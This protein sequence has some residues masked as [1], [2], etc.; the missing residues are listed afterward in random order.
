MTQMNSLMVPPIASLSPS[1]MIGAV[2]D[3]IHVIFG[4]AQNSRWHVEAPFNAAQEIKFLV[5]SVKPY[6]ECNRRKGR[7]E[8]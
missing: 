4:V 5:C 3:A 1:L 6:A 8:R 2:K 7:G